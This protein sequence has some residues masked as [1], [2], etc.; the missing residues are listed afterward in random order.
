[1]VCVSLAD[2]D[3]AL[4]ALNG[5]SCAEIRIDLMRLTVEDVGRLFCSHPNLIATCRPGVFSDDER[6]RRLFVAVESGAAYADVEL[7]SGEA[8]REEIVAKAQAHGCQVIIS[9]HDFQKTPPG[10]ELLDIVSA[11]FDVGADIAKIA[12]LVHSPRDNARL[13]GLLDSHRKIVVVG[14]GQMGTVT[15]IMAPLLGSPFT[16]ASLVQGQETAE[17]QIDR[18]CL[19]SWLSALERCARGGEAG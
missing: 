6:M 3:A 18:S 14:M 4:A 15:R 19:E 17:G 2:F 8:Y 12:C 10:K 13:L 11:C 9:H 7:D 5:I 16:Y 1:M